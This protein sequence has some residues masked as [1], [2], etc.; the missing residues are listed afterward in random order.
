MA[1]YVVPSLHPKPEIGKKKKSIFQALPRDS[2][3]IAIGSQDFS[4]QEREC[5][6]HKV[7]H[8][9]EF[10]AGKLPNRENRMLLNVKAS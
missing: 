7:T 2:L 4:K 3:S 6:H 8:T 9:P 10:L 1:K 5:S